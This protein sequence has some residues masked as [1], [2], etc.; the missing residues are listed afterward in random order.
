MKM[1][2]DKEWFKKR[3]AAE[4][5][6]DVGVGFSIVSP[7]EADIATMERIVF[8]SLPQ[9]AQDE[10]TKLRAAVAALAHPGQVREIAIK[11]LEWVEQIS[12]EWWIADRYRVE[13]FDGGGFAARSKGPHSGSLVTLCFGV[14]FEAAKAAAQADFEQRIRSALALPLPV[15]EPVAFTSQAQLDKA[16]AFPGD[17]LIMWGEPLPY[18]GDIPLYLSP[19]PSIP[20][21]KGTAESAVALREA[22]EWYGEQARLARLVH[23]GGDKGRY[24]LADDGGKRAREVLSSSSEAKQ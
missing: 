10:L 8:K 21:E 9:W 4:G 7:S 5:D 19:F 15:Q 2:I 17:N 18:H 14:S 1:P 3:V 22:L 12:G 11:P 20:E 16:K 23:S 6:L 24:A 13:K